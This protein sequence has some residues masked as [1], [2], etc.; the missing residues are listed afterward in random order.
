LGPESIQLHNGYIY[1]GV[2]SGAI[3]RFSI[4]SPSVL[5]TVVWLNSSCKD[6]PEVT[7]YE[8]YP[9][10]REPLCGRPLGLRVDSNKQS[11]LIVDAY[12]G[13]LEY[14]L[15]TNELTRLSNGSKLANDLDFDGDDVFFTESSPRWGRNKIIFEILSGRNTGKVLH[16]DR[17]TKSVQ[18]LADNLPLTNGITLSHD[19]QTIFFIAGPAV[20]AIDR[21]SRKYRGIVLDNLPC[22]PDN[23]RRHRDG[24]S[25]LV[26]SGTLRST[27]FSLTDAL[28]GYP[29]LREFIAYASFYSQV[30]LLKLMPVYGIVLQLE[31]DVDDKRIVDS[32]QDPSGKFGWMSEAEVAGEFLYI[33][34]WKENFITRIPLSKIPF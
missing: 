26:A 3:V 22:I 27:P 28:S 31:L 29:M 13:I 12:S 8:A 6:L 11:L 30:N 32:I 33:G 5:E 25:Y 17:R 19:K 34:S 10:D 7:E 14:S 16:L 9:P 2:M 20:H 24:V 23:I 15:V 21:R 1:T 18:V 4:A